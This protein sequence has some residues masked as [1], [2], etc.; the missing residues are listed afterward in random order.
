MIVIFLYRQVKANALVAFGQ[1]NEDGSDGVHEFTYVGRIHSHRERITGVEFGYREGIEL[2]VSVS[3]DRRCVEYDVETSCLTE[4]VLP[5]QAE[6]A[7]NPCKIESVAKPLAIM[8]HPR[9]EDDAEDKFIISNDEFKFKEFNADSKQC[10]RTTLAPTF[11]GP[12][13]MLLPVRSA[14]GSV[15]H[16]AYSTY[17]KVIGVGCFPLTGDPAKVMGLVAHPLDISSI[18][19]SFDG[20]FVFSAGGADLAVN[21]WAVDTSALDDRNVYPEYDG[22]EEM[23]NNP[24]FTIATFLPLLE[25]GAGGE[26]HQDII[27]YFYYCQLRAQGEDA[28]ESRA[29]VGKIPLEE[30]PSLMRAVGFYPSEEEVANMLNEVS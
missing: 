30:V 6:G 18:A 15:G 28:M 25:G 21:M 26:L 10:R 27:D 23:K 5:Y 14:D 19:I 7:I 1:K 3:E 11:G 13:N 12:P 8:W 20:K 4:G 17:S 16:Y 29:I 2:L 22:S 24:D 9:L